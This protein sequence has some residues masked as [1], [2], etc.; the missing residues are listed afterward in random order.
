MKS[1]ANSPGTSKTHTYQVCLINRQGEEF[2]IFGPTH[3]LRG[4]REVALKQKPRKKVKLYRDNKL[5]PNG[6][7]GLDPYMYE[8]WWKMKEEENED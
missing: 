8:Y 2:T 4:A 1:T 5:L 7:F 3:S 6:K